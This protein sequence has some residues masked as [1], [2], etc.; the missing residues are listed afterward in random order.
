MFFREWIYDETYG[1]SYNILA[2]GD[3]LE[4]ASIA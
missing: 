4:I 2:A 1:L 3:S